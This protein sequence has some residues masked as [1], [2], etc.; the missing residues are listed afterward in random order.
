MISF[1]YDT[2]K[3]PARKLMLFL[4]QNTLTKDFVT[5]HN[6]VQYSPL[7]PHISIPISWIRL[8]SSPLGLLKTVYSIWAY[9]YKYI[10]QIN[11]TKINR[12]WGKMV[13]SRRLH[14]RWAP[15]RDNSS[16]PFSLHPKVTTQS[17]SVCLWHLSSFCHFLAAQV[18][19]RRAFL[20]QLQKKLDP[21]NWL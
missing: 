1:N 16:C 10:I 18:S 2:F 8:S 12:I 7:C 9:Y 15:H 6:H 17:F 19:H 11:I 5:L 3:S 14:V 21:S 20:K 13:P 4:L